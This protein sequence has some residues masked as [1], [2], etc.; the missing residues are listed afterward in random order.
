MSKRSIAAHLNI[1][2]DP[3]Y[4]PPKISTTFSSIRQKVRSTWENFEAVEE[5]LVRLDEEV[6]NELLKYISAHQRATPQQVQ[7]KKNRL[8]ICMYEPPI[9]EAET[10]SRELERGIG[11][12]EEAAKKEA[13]TVE[14]RATLEIDIGVMRNCLKTTRD[15]VDAARVQFEQARKSLEVS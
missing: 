2:I 6:H 13:E 3:N 1:A 7:V 10:C 15:I 8:T 14:S 11:D 4:P 12:L 5:R 9:T